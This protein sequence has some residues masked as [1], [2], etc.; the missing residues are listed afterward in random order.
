M[1]QTSTDTYIQ[2]QVFVFQNSPSQQVRE[3]ALWR[4]ASHADLI[5]PGIQT[6]EGAAR[7]AV[8]DWLYELGYL[9]D[10]EG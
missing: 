4:L 7:T 3:D 8:I 10:R 2:K 6:L 9:V 5:P 1:T